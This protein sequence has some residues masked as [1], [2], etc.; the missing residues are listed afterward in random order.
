LKPTEK[1]S[2]VIPIRNEVKYIARTI[3][4]LLQQDYPSDLVEILVVD[5]DSDDGTAILLKEQRSRAE[6]PPRPSVR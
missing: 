5:G 4:Y 1:I 2:V 3:R 6:R